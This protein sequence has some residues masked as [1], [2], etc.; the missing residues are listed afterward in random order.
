MLDPGNPSC[1][2]YTSGLSEYALSFV[3]NHVS[4]PLARMTVSSTIRTILPFSALLI[5]LGVTGVLSAQD[6]VPFDPANASFPSSASFSSIPAFPFTSD[7]VQC[8]APAI[9]QNVD[10]LSQL[11]R[12]YEDQKLQFV[13]QK[14]QLLI[15]AWAIPERSARNTAIRGVQRS[16]DLAVRSLDRWFR[17]Q[18]RAI[19]RQFSDAVSQC[20]RQFDS[21]VDGESSSSSS[22][23]FSSSFGFSSSSGLPQCNGGDV[24][25][26]YQV[27]RDTNGTFQDPGRCGDMH[28]LNYCCQIGNASSLSSS[29]SSN[30]LPQ[31]NG[32][33]AC[34]PYQVCIDS[35]GTFEDPGRCGDSNQFNYCCQVGH[36]V[37]SSSSSSSGLPRCNGGDL[38]LPYQ[39]CRD[40][41]GTFQDPGRCGD[42]SQLNYCCQLPNDVHSSSSSSSFVFCDSGDMCFPVAK[43]NAIGGNFVSPGA[44]GTQEMRQEGYYC[45]RQSSSSS[46]IFYPRN[47]TFNAD[48]AQ[49]DQTSQQS[50]Q[51]CACQTVCDPSGSPCMAVCPAQC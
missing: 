5:A 2:Q 50:I 42:S 47:D 25:V 36:G 26:P 44:C 33:D 30:G 13:Q 51:S 6:I 12:T 17:D 41:N 19:N 11:Q 29:S 46:R 32:G 7:Y 21:D 16:Y 18:E 24:C 38:C 3:C 34:V 49:V 40:N 10:R 4:F 43:C 14:S 28:Q 23:R 8:V 35:K 22:S 15:T 45:C 20:D 9:R 37:S 1:L 39:T 27:C 48:Q 31:C